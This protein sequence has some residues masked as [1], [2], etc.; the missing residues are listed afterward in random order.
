[1]HSHRTQLDS[2]DSGSLWQQATSL[3]H[4]TNTVDR[5]RCRDTNNATAHGMETTTA[6][7]STSGNRRFVSTWR[8]VR[9][10]PLNVSNEEVFTY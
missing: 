4:A 10:A 8:T 3:H 7:G 2:I 6:D 9:P 1:M 5:Y